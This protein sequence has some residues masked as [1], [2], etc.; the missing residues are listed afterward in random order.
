MYVIRFR[1]NER[2]ASYALFL[3]SR[4]VLSPLKL[5]VLLACL[6]NW[7]EQNHSRL[8]NLDGGQGDSPTF[9][10]VW[11]RKLHCRA[12]DRDRSTARTRL[13]SFFGSLAS[14]KRVGITKVNPQQRFFS[15]FLLLLFC[16]FFVF[17]LACTKRKTSADQNGSAARDATALVVG[18]E[19]ERERER[20]ST[21]EAKISACS[22]VTG[23]G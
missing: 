8:L 7:V 9:L 17:V 14:V 10:G 15:F 1:E 21:V 6:G 3:T 20:E 13:I 11:D 2:E 5:V 16:F 18:R 23:N 4:G 22:H 12:T 19:R